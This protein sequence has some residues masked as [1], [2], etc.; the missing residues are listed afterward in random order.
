[1]TTRLFLALACALFVVRLPSLVQPMGADQGLYAYVGERIL[2]GGL[3]YRDAWDQKP[4]AIHFVYAGLRAVWPYDSVVAAAD[5][6][7]AAV[8]AFLLYRLGMLLAKPATGQAAALLF[9]FLANPSF[10]RLSGVAMRAQAET[11][12]AAVV[13]GALLL[14]LRPAASAWTL[15]AGGLLLGVAFTFKYNMVV[16]AA[17]AV[18]MLML[19]PGKGRATPRRAAVFVAL[20]FIVPVVAFAVVFI[21]RGAVRDLYEATI[22]YNLQ[23]SGE[24]YRGPVDAAR[25]LLSFPIQHARVDGLWLLG[26]AACAVLLIASFWRRERLIA[27]VWVAAACAAI[28]INSSRGLPQYFVQAAPALALAA[29]WAG[30]VLWSKRTIVNVVALGVIAFGV[31]RVNNFQKLLENTWHD[32]RYVAGSMDREQHLARYGEPNVRKYSAIA[33]E[34]LAQY[35]RANSA[36]QDPVYIFGF[37]PGAYVK[38]DRVSASRFFWSRPVIAGFNEGMRGYGAAGVLADLEHRPPIVIALQ[39]V[40]WLAD[41]DNSSQYFTS[42]PAL[43]PWLRANYVAAAGPVGFDFWIRRGATP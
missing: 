34:H 22:T 1:M 27:P 5:L 36:P 30:T 10:A 24:T 31:W 8:T 7:A 38:A 11:F 2:D 4:P 21:F 12:I 13:T 43:G 29:A 40:D 19:A 32:T 37:S 6:A 17:A 35:L 25:Y 16:Y 23:Y 15:A 14:L 26:G 9:L 20:G 18:V 33:V 28:A 41:V 42:H 39:Q 3:P